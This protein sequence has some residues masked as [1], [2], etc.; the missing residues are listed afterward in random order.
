MAFLSY[1]NSGIEFNKVTQPSFTTSGRISHTRYDIDENNN[2]INRQG[3]TINA[4]DIDWNN[5]YLDTVG[6]YINTTG[7]LLNQINVLSNAIAVGYESLNNKFNS[8]NIYTKEESDDKYQEKG[9]YVTKTYVDEKFN[10]LNTI[11]TQLQNSIDLINNQI[12]NN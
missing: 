9:N 11:I 5:A 12:N 4:I 2:I 10:E 1:T 3:K 8:L 7:D 6:T